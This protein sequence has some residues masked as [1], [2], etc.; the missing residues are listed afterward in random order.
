[1]CVVKVCLYVCVREKEREHYRL[2]FGCVCVH[3]RVRAKL[4]FMYVSEDQ[5]SQAWYIQSCFFFIA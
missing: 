1:M 2:L 3:V 4:H 5:N